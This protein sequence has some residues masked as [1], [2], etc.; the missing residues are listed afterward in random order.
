MVLGGVLLAAAVVPAAVHAQ[1]KVCVSHPAPQDGSVACVRNSAHI[2]D[3]CDRKD[4]GHR[5]YARVVTR[6]TYPAFRSPYYDSN[7]HNAPVTAA[8]GAK[9]PDD[10]R[11]SH[12][13]PPPSTSRR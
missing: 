10:A 4:D 11:Q 13:Q 6:G 2:L 3:V 1:D 8:N 5:A 12:T 7:N 9:S